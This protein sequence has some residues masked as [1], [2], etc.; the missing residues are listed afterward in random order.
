M[1]GWVSQRNMLAPIPRERKSMRRAMSLSRPRERLRQLDAVQA[2]AGIGSQVKM[3]RQPS[4]RLAWTPKSMAMAAATRSD[5]AT[6][7]PCGTEID[8]SIASATGAVAPRLQAVRN[9]YERQGG[10]RRRRASGRS[11]T[12]YPAAGAGQRQRGRWLRNSPRDIHPIH[13]NPRSRI[14]SPVPE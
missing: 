4:T 12:K 14:R 11:P 2:S 3:A 1:I 8:P 13:R 7:E 5:S 9:R 10:R 6:A